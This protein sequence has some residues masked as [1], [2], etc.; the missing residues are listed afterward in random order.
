MT[1]HQAVGAGD[2]GKTQRVLVSRSR[3][4]WLVE[5]SRSAAIHDERGLEARR[6]RARGWAAAVALVVAASCRKGA[7]VEEAPRSA[8]E[9]AQQFFSSRCAA[10]HGPQGRGDGAAAAGLSPRPRDFADRS[11]HARATDEHLRRLLV[12]GGAAV[13]LS[14]MMPPSPELATD[15][16]LRDA[17][18]DVVR[19]MMAGR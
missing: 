7:A 6:R 14:A 12:G 13:G 5:R 10:C 8:A 16:A 19:A 15:G 9:R 1:K 4:G 18:V 2:V 3:R 11:W 17:L